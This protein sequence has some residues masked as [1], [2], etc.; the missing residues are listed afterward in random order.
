MASPMLGQPPHGP[1][2]ALAIRDLRVRVSPHALQRDET[3]LRA[4]VRRQLPGDLDP[5]LAGPLTAELVRA[6]RHAIEGVRS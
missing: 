1:V 4:V 5:E 2:P 3:A 6:V